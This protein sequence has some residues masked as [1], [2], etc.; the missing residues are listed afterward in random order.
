MQFYFDAAGILAVFSE[1][2]FAAIPLFF[3]VLHYF[4]TS[5]S[6][7][8]DVLVGRRG[9]IKWSVYR[10]ILIVILLVT[11]N[12]IASAVAYAS[13]DLFSR[14]PSIVFE[15]RAFDPVS[16]ALL[17]VEKHHVALNNADRYLRSE[18]DYFSPQ[19]DV[20]ASKTLDF[21]GSMTA[22]YIGFVDFR[23]QRRLSVS[24]DG[25][26]ASLRL[27][28]GNGEVSSKQI[29]VP[30]NLVIDAGFDR[31]IQQRWESLLKGEALV[32]PFFAQTRGVLFDF[33]IVKESVGERRVQFMVRPQNRFLRWFVDPIQ[34]SYDKST[35]QLKRYQGLTNIQRMVGNKLVDEYFVARIEYEYLL[36]K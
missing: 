2:V 21:A 15:G 16:N 26:V 36:N 27:S 14:M 3:L 20:F 25:V 32:F 19:G 11:V 17:Y 28:D 30:D 18:V 6:L 35:R 12:G 13:S 8:A 29:D 5:T 34:L 7:V 24:H 23:S 4:V 31:L 22:P 1:M 33:E 10:L 9:M